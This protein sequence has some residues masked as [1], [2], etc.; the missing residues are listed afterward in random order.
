MRRLALV[1]GILVFGL[2]ALAQ[3]STAAPA[4]STPVAPADPPQTTAASTAPAATVVTAPPTATT[5]S[6]R[7]A[8]VQGPRAN[9]TVHLGDEITV[10]ITGYPA[11]K[12]AADA[13]QK[14]V[15]LWL[16]GIDS[17][18]EPTGEFIVMR[19]G[20]ADPSS[21][22]L[23]FPLTRTSENNELW[24][25]LLH[26]PFGERTEK[27]A[28]SAGVSGDLP[29]L[30]ADN[31][32]GQLTLEKTFI[33]GFST[34]WMILLAILI[35][36]LFRY[37]GDML[38]SGPDIDGKK[39]AFSLGRS[40]MAWWFVLIIASYV[41]IWLIT[42]DRDTITSSLLVLMGISAGTALG[43]VAIDSG[44][45]AKAQTTRT[46]L[47]NERATLEATKST[48][49]S[50]AT[51][52]SQDAQ[53]AID[54]RMKEIDQNVADV[55]RPPM[56]TGNWLTDVLT[57]NNGQIALHRFQVLAWTVVLG[58]IFIASVVRDLT[59]PEFNTTLLTLMGISSG[60]YLGFK[61]PTNS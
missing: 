39:Q 58:L 61:I 49:E 22:T 5:S 23:R 44:A 43:A 11:L 56:T 46:N 31:V 4:T 28:V 59:M 21:R 52:Q 1:L 24:R 17:Q 55:T 32:N 9:G 16:D 48:L 54:L 2:P 38:R 35:V 6:S 18:L 42:G 14:P 26:D 10:T 15:T 50:A 60:T 13:R 8:A 36:L 34:L 41:V 12:S 40:Q 30:L 53:N 25:N 3:T 45:P 27:M 20:K 51:P 37:G 33:T 47:T 7:I 57:D 29:L 19:N